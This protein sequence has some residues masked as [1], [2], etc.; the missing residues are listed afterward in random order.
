MV[1]YLKNKVNLTSGLVFLKKSKIGK[2]L[3]AWDGGN[4]GC[5][6]V[7]MSTARERGGQVVILMFLVTLEK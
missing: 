1:M 6:V 5:R 4:G 2:E 7:G 3:G